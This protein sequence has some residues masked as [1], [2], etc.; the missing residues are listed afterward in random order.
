MSPFTP[1][2]SGGRAVLFHHH[3]PLSLRS[4]AHSGPL[5]CQAGWCKT[6]TLG[7]RERSMTGP[8]GE[9]VVRVGEKDGEPSQ[10]PASDSQQRWMW[11]HSLNGCL[12]ISRPRL[13]VA[14]ST[15]S[16]LNHSFVW[17][18][19]ADTLQSLPCY[20]TPGET[21]RNETKKV[22]CQERFLCH[23]RRKQDE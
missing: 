9:N 14:R 6:A 10:N 17:R 8:G 23:W 18:S 5:C 19:A 22:L 7:G 2:N 4:A 11:I 3:H 15:G 16:P 12:M 20:R 21:A 13:R 1:W